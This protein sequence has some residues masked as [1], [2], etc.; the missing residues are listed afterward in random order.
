MAIKFLQ[1]LPP[2]IRQINELN[3]HTHNTRNKNMLKV[4]KGN[5][6]YGGKMYRSNKSQIWNELPSLLQ[7][8]EVPKD[9]KK[10]YKKRK[11]NDYLNP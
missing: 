5:N 6:R 10:L 9:F 7:N 3:P 2:P 11:L 1:Y 4:Y 8:A